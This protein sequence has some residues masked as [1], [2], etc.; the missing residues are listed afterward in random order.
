MNDNE[1]VSSWLTDISNQLHRLDA[2]L[3]RTIYIVIGLIILL[4]I[5]NPLTF[6]YATSLFK[7]LILFMH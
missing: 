3:N 5:A 1:I 2:K 6:Q 4:V 7:L